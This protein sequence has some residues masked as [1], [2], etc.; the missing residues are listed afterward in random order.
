MTCGQAFWEGGTAQ[1]GG[2]RFLDA[3]AD[4]LLGAGC[5]SCRTPSLGVCPSCAAI[6][7]QELPHGVRRPGLHTAVVAAATYR[8]LLERI[9]PRFKDDG[10]WGL[11]R[12][13]ADLL[14]RSVSRHDPPPGI[15]LVPVPS[16][17]EAVRRRGL[18]HGRVLARGAAMRLGIGWAALLSRTP[19]GLG[20]RSLDRRGRLALSATGFHVRAT[21]RPVLLV[22]D[23]ITTGATLRSAAEALEQAGVRVTGAAVIADA[24]TPH[25]TKQPCHPFKGE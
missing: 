3:A 4:L 6:L 24:D 16:R 7:R 11:A 9:I 15:L 19:G 21:A 14:A 2:V 1:D 10:A 5:P 13:L 20:Q 23:V 12:F 8:P 18:D 17:A 22:D 25:L